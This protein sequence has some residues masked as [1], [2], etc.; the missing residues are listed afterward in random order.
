MQSGRMALPVPI[1]VIE[2]SQWL[3]KYRM[4]AAMRHDLDQIRILEEELLKQSVRGSP[5]AVGQLLADDFIEFGR[6]GGVHRKDEV[7]GSLAAEGGGAVKVRTASDFDLKPLADD[8]VLLTYRSLRQGADGQELHT[9]RSS[10]WKFI[11][12]RWQ[13]VFHQGTPTSGR[14]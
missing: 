8:V 12:G 3:P 11:E 4:Y 14:S 5:E 13:M 6:S 10:I 1:Y 2:V 7:I 9:L